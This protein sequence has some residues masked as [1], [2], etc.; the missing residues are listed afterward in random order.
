MNK[1]ILTYV[2]GIGL[3]IVGMG[4]PWQV[5]SQLSLIQLMLLVLAIFR[6]AR[7]VSFDTVMEWL[8]A[9]F[10]KTV[11]DPSGAG[12]TTGPMGKGWRRVVGELLVCP[13]CV[14]MWITL[15]FMFL[16]VS[17]AHELAI[18]SIYLFGIMGAVEILQAAFEFVQWNGE[19]ARYRAGVLRVGHKKDSIA[20]PDGLRWMKCQN[21]WNKSIMGDGD[22]QAEEKQA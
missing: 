20:C 14:G 1:L 6:I 19:L 12:M 5:L 17:E 16:L 21:A 7:M 8:R 22:G 18:D 10:A 15:S 11:V 13:I 4:Q 3:V 2:F 9:P